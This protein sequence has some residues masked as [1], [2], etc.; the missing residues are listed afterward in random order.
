MVQLVKKY[1]RLEQSCIEGID[2]FNGKL[3]NTIIAMKR[4]TYDY[5][6]YRK[7]EFDTD[8]EDFKQIVVDI[9]VQLIIFME[10]TLNKTV[11]L[12]MSLSMLS[13]FQW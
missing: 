7:V 4:K 10:R 12:P 2:V 6:D 3:A 5:L 8:F 11:T 13:R 9:E 1:E